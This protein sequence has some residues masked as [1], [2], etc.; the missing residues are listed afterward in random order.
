MVV[1]VAVDAW[2]AQP[3][4][5]VDLHPAAVA[6]RRVAMPSSRIGI[7]ILRDSDTLLRRV[8]RFRWRLFEVEF[9]TFAD[10][11]D[12]DSTHLHSSKEPPWSKYTVLACDLGV[13]G[14]T[15]LRRG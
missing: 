6:T 2:R 3:A 9:E 5:R 8:S 10:Q 1:V 7:F 4:R 14:E 13:V 12:P 11:S 15:G